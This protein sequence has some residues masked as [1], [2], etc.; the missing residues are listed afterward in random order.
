MP[1]SFAPAVYQNRECYDLVLRR[2]SAA[3]EISMKRVFLGLL[4]P[5]GLV[6]LS[7]GCQ[8]S[9]TPAKPA[10][11]AGTAAPASQ[12]AAGQAA[13][14][15][16][17]VPGAIAPGAP[18]STPAGQPGEAPVKPVP[19]ILPAVVAT[20]NGEGV[21]KWE[22][23]AAL[24]QAEATAGGPVPADKRDSVLRSILDEIVTYHLLA[25]EAQNRKMGVTP[26]DVDAEMLKIRQDFPTEDAYKQA[27]LLQGVTVEQLRDVTQRAIQA[28][29]IVDAEVT[30]KIAVQDA[31]VDAFYKQN[32]DRFKQGDTVH[33][34]HIYLAV[35][36]DAPPAEKNQ[37]RAAATELL[38][39]LRAGADFAKIARDNSSDPSAA[40]GGDLGFFGKGDMPPDFEKVA[41][42]LK[43]GTMSGVV[44]LQT[45][46]HIIKVQERR[47]PRTAPL[48][49]VR[50]SVKE[51]L[52]NGQRQTKLDELV[53]Q[54]K[55]KSKIQIL[56]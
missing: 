29:K 34:S 39:Q 3:L 27:L 46:L 12:P 56:V 38:K 50:D 42:E 2:S 47:G 11:G 55:A 44:E 6:V 52:L 10:A 48:A 45:G 23:E 43:P 19:A 17:G 36:P 31:E 1:A 41:F 54:I 4:L 5:V 13:V 24:K 9:G 40:N 30:T 14:P 7:A 15:P 22:V 35:A 49:E 32:I 53:G 28:R 33:A 51:F 37:K 25:Q 21:Q 20:V 26:T 8:K 18:G 16:P